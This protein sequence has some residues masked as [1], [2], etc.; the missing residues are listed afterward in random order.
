MLL[1]KVVGTVVAT[2]GKAAVLP[3]ETKISFRVSN[4]VT[5]TEKRRRS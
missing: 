5:I 4:A 1:A 3:S 2:R